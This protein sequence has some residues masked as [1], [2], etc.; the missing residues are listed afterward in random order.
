M[1]C[2]H[3]L[4]RAHTVRKARNHN[5]SLCF[6]PWMR[7]SWMIRYTYSLQFS[8]GFF[9]FSIVFSHAKTI[10]LLWKGDSFFFARSPFSW[11]QIFQESLVNLDI[12]FSEWNS[13]I[14]LVTTVLAQKEG[15]N[16]MWKKWF[17]NKLNLLVVCTLKFFRRVDWYPLNVESMKYLCSIFRFSYDFTV[18]TVANRYIEQVKTSESYNDVVAQ[19]MISIDSLNRISNSLYCVFLLHFVRVMAS[20]GTNTQ[21]NN[22]RPY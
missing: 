21:N 5:R 10:V 13:A 3:L 2:C 12:K 14:F 7:Q 18:N 16:C 11:L 17:E 9:C 8:V 22:E 4:R 6:M 1:G 15:K 20:G 19:L